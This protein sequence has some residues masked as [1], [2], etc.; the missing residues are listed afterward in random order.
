ML[1]YHTV[2]QINIMDKS[3][4]NID[5]KEPDMKNVFLHYS[6]YIKYE[7]GKCNLWGVDM[8][9]RKHERFFFR[10]CLGNGYIVC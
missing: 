1:E 7:M 6:I 10:L 2:I 3:L 5:Q 8:T 4:N 9:E